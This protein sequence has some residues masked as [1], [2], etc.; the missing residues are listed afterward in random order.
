MGKGKGGE[1]SGRE[2][3]GERRV[4]GSGT[5]VLFLSVSLYLS[6]FLSFVSSIFFLFLGLSVSFVF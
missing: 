5:V 2:E 4:G 3:R 1:G 6:L